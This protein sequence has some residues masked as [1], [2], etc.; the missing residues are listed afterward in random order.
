M[1]RLWGRDTSTN[2][3]KVLWLSAELGLTVDH[4]QVG[5]PFGGLDTPEF[6]RLNPNGTIPVLEY[7]TATVWES[8]AILRFLA[9]K[10]GATG[11]YPTDSEARSFDDSWLD[12]HSNVY[13]PPIR[14]LFLEGWRDKVLR[15][16][17]G[18]GKALFTRID[19]NMSLLAENRLTDVQT[20][21]Q[22]LRLSDIPLAVGI[23][24]LRTM[25]P[26]YELPA[27]VEDWF[28]ALTK[29]P[30]FDVVHHAETKLRTP[31]HA[32]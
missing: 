3:Q 9:T 4:R 5:G 27:V 15:F 31:D 18:E 28:E 14:T 25:L 11:I 13:W 8:H 21:D 22:G 7:G 32:G 29:R 1:I 20:L 24:R 10:T 16:E 17:S 30:A 2:V 12:W 26:E 6:R 19:H 23:S